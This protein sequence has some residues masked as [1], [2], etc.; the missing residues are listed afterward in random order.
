[1]V[2]AVAV[3]AWYPL[4]ALA[5]QQMADSTFHPSVA[6]PAFTARHP[7]VLFDEGHHTFHTLGGRYKPFA[8]LLRSDGCVLTPNTETFTMR[9]LEQNDLLVIANALGDDPNTG[10]TE[11]AERSAFTRREIEMVLDWVERGGAL[12]LIADHAPFG[13]AASDLAERLGV[14]MSKGYTADSLQAAPGMQSLTFIEFTTAAGSLGEHAI[15][16]G[17]NE[18]ERIDKVVAFTG[19]SLR[20]SQGSTSLMRLSDAAIDIPA[21]AMKDR[22]DADAI[23]R[24]S[25]SAKGRSMGVAFPLGKGRVVVLGEAGMLSAQVVRYPD[26]RLVKFGMNRPGNENQQFA[27]NVVRWLVGAL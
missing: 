26:G 18:A 5:Q 12:L 11:S 17:R 16:K 2:A 14:G 21:A 23:Q 6:R 7:R 10:T 1:V 13:A 4:P 9:T 22:G 19:Q 3:L 25:V 24:A 20:G 8:E 15:T 27:L